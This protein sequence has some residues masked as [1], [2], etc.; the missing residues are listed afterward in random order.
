MPVFVTVKKRLISFDPSRPE[1]PMLECSDP[2]ELD[3]RVPPPVIVEVNA[4][5]TGV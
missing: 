5:E 4:T 3:E 2:V 1:V